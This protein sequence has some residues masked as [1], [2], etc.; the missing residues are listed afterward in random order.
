[1]ASTITPIERW[2]RGETP[3]L[4]S[5]GGE[6]METFFRENALG[7]VSIDF[8]RFWAWADQQEGDPLRSEKSKSVRKIP[9]KTFLHRRYKEDG[10]ENERADVIAKSFGNTKDYGSRYELYARMHILE[11]RG[12]WYNYNPQA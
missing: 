4:E 2:L 7:Q 10:E 1:M 3:S 12:E 11:H 6:T 5:L 9:L 8:S